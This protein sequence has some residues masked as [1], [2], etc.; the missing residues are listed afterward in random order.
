MKRAV[1]ATICLGSARASRAG[2]DAP[3]VTNFA[4]LLLQVLS[5]LRQLRMNGLE[6]FADSL[7]PTRSPF[8]LPVRR[9]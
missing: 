9:S 5:N 8:G 3:A 2:D 6:V 4:G 1:I 7:L